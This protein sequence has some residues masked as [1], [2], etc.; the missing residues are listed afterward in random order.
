M[1]AE[2]KSEARK[3]ECRADFLDCSDRDLQRQVDS[4]RVDIYCTNQ[5]YEETRKGQA[6]LLK[7]WL[8]EREFFEKLR[9]EVFMMWECERTQYKTY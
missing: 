8:S 1:L 3:Q 9:S 2:A 5:G 4:D 7:N 6:R